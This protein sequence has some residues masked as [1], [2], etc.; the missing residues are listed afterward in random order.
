MTHSIQLGSFHLGSW[1]NILH[2]KSSAGERS[3]RGEMSPTTVLKM[4]AS[5]QAMW[6]VSIIEGLRRLRQ[7]CHEFETS[8]DYSKNSKNK[9]KQTN[10]NKNYQKTQTN[11]KPKQKSLH[12]SDIERIHHDTVRATHSQAR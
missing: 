6:L 4:R 3:K 5:S 10:N 9:S 12:K 11:Q 2:M 7:E 8:L 1:L